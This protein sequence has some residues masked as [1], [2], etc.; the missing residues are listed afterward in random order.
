MTGMKLSVIAGMLLLVAIIVGYFQ[1]APNPTDNIVI[2]SLTLVKDNSLCYAEGQAVNVSG[3]D[4]ISVKIGVEFN[5]NENK[6]VYSDTVP[7]KMLTKGC[8]VTFRVICP[9]D[10]AKQVSYVEA[11]PR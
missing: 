10:I 8:F 5:N 9:N 11:G 3:H 7:V 4:L 2:T 6:I 1:P